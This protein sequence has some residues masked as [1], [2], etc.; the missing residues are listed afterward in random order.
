MSVLYGF[1]VE[2]LED[3]KPKNYTFIT[4]SILVYFLHFVSQHFF[5][6]KMAQVYLFSLNT[7]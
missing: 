6:P 1:S 3:S 4:V 7:I 5:F 2:N